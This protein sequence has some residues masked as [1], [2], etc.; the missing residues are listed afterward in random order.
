[1]AST[2]AGPPPPETTADDGPIHDLL[3]DIAAGMPRAVETWW[4]PGER[5][6]Y[7]F[8][9]PSKRVCP[10]AIGGPVRLSTRP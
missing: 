4:C 7:G 1:M 9:Y 6:G 10:R 8:V 3:R 5:T 2:D